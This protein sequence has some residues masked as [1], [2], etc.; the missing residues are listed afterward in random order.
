MDKKLMSRLRPL[1]IYNIL[2]KETDKEHPLGTNDIIKRLEEKGA[3]CERRALQADIKALQEC[4]YPI[5]RIAKKDYKYY[6]ENRELT[7]AELTDA[8]IAVLIDAVQSVTFLTE[9]ATWEIINK[10]TTLGG[11]GKA[12]KDEFLDSILYNSVHKTENKEVLGS[13]WEIEEAILKQKKISFNYFHLNYKFEQEFKTKDNKK[14]LYTVSPIA[15][16]ISNGNYYLLAYTESHKNLSIYRIDRMTNVKR[17]DQKIDIKPEP[18][19][20]EIFKKQLF[21]MYCGSPLTVKI[22]THKNLLNKMYDT[23]GSEQITPMPLQNDPDYFI[24]TCEVM[25]SPMF[26]AWCCSYG[27]K[28]EVLSPASFIQE[29]KEY[30]K[31]LYAM[32]NR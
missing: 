7:D 10:L 12:K 3:E 9:D 27:D 1:F 25:N 23:F 17:L 18:E 22:K 4:G 24:I 19:E 13:A 32:Y 30:T 29:L 6:I 28:L 14:K 31:S 21:E 26:K 20:I 16:T 2:K 8:E 15:K 11:G 5:E